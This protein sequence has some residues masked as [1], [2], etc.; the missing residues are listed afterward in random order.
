MVF[1]SIR[2]AGPAAATTNFATQLSDDA[3]A[4]DNS[5]APTLNTP[6]PGNDT[7][8]GLQWDMAQIHAPEARAITGG[9]GAGTSGAEG[10]TNPQFGQCPDS[11]PVTTRLHGR[12]RNC[13]GIRRVVMLPR[14]SIAPV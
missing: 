8:S 6:A 13:P 12:Q 11:V 10:G 9:T 5:A 4:A 14:P 7:L 2:N 3:N 1:G